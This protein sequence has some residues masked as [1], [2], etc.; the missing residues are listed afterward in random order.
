[1]WTPPSISSELIYSTVPHNFERLSRKHLEEGAMVIFGDGWS[2][3]NEATLKKWAAW[4]AESEEVECLT[5]YPTKK[6]N[7]REPHL[8]GQAYADKLG[9]LLLSIQDE[10][11]D[12]NWSFVAVPFE[13]LEMFCEEPKLLRRVAG[14]ELLSRPCLYYLT[15]GS[16]EFEEVGRLCSKQ[17]A[18]PWNME[19]SRRLLV[20]DVHTFR[21]ANHLMIIKLVALMMETDESCDECGRESAST[22]RKLA[23]NAMAGLAHECAVQY[24]NMV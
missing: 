7:G 19:P 20:S 22:L 8:G 11:E 24:Q 12:C 4:V 23:E 18:A 2:C 15:E 6:E 3:I 17:E 5:K 16:M 1:M 9:E 10:V 14:P 13:N 21:T